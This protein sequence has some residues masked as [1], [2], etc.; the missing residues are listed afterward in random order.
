ME[1]ATAS[2][3]D[4]RAALLSCWRMTGGAAD[5]KPP[6]ALLPPLPADWHQI[7]DV[8]TAFAPGCA[9][10]AGGSLRD[11][12]LGRREKDIDIFVDPRW[13]GDHVLSQFGAVTVVQ[14]ADLAADSDDRCYDDSINRIV[15]LAT[16]RGRI[17]Q[18]I[19]RPRLVD[20]LNMISLFDFGICRCAWTRGEGWIVHPDFLEDL[21]AR[22]FKV[23]CDL[24]V[25]HTRR[26]ALRFADR[27]PDWAID[28]SYIDRDSDGDW[29][30]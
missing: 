19:E 5:W 11:V 14:Q 1:A 4:L 21:A 3:A 16:T 17:F 9:Y 13:C 24:Y 28:T 6:S 15:E 2:P 18:I 27:F 29:T 23:R 25:E 7:L 10:I 20:P 22:V 30:L 8:V 12:I 26:R